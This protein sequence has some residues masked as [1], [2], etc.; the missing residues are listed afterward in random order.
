M[1]D[2]E[3]TLERIS[4]MMWPDAGI[5]RYTR[6]P[7]DQCEAAAL[8]V[9]NKLRSQNIDYEVR[10]LLAWESAEASGPEENHFVVIAK[11]QGH[12]IVI[13]MTVGQFFGTHR[14][15]YIIQNEKTWEAEFL[16]LESNQ[17]KLFKFKDFANMQL[18]SG[19]FWPPDLRF[20]HPEL[21][22]L[23]EAPSW[24]RDYFN[25]PRWG[26][27][28]L[29]YLDATRQPP[30][31]G[32]SAYTPEQRVAAEK[33]LGRLYAK[34]VAPFKEI[35]NKI[36]EGSLAPVTTL[37]T[38]DQL[39]NEAGAPAGT[40]Y[41]EI[42]D[43]LHLFHTQASTLNLAQKHAWLSDLAQL[44]D[45]YVDKHKFS[46]NGRR[47]KLRDFAR[48]VRAYA[49]SLRLRQGALNLQ[50]AVGRGQ[51][52]APSMV[53]LRRALQ[54]GVTD[55]EMGFDRQFLIQLTG[56]DA[57][58]SAAHNL[59]S[60]HPNK[61]EWY[62]CSQGA[63]NV[64]L[65]ASFGQFPP[66]GGGRYKFVLIGHGSQGAGGAQIG[67]LN[68]L[69]LPGI[70]NNAIANY[71]EGIV[72]QEGGSIDFRL[73]SLHV[74]LL[75]CELVE[76]FQAPEHTLP[77][78]LWERLVSHS[79]A[80]LSLLTRNQI[81]VTA[82]EYPVRVTDA[83]KKE[84]L[85]REWGW[86]GKEEARVKNVLYKVEI[87]NDPAT[88]RMMRKPIDWEGLNLLQQDLN[89]SPCSPTGLLE[90]GRLVEG[91]MHAT[92][93]EPATKSAL[94]GLHQTLGDEVRA[95]FIADVAP[96]AAQ[97]NMTAEQ[98]VVNIR[99]MA[100]GEQWA[101]VAHVLKQANELDGGD[102]SVTLKTRV[103][104]SGDTEVMFIRR[105]AS[106]STVPV[107]WVRT[108]AEQLTTLTSFKTELARLTV[109]VTKGL[110][111]SHAAN[112]VSVR[113]DVAEEDI[114]HTLNAAFMLQTLLD[115]GSNSNHYAELST[116]VKIEVFAGLSQFAFQSTVDG[117]RLIRFINQ[118]L[119][120]DVRVLAVASNGLLSRL[121]P[122]ANFVFNA[123]FIG[124]TIA[125]L[126]Q[127]TDPVVAEA[128]KVKLGLA[129]VYSG[130]D[131]TA[132]AAGLAGAGVVSGVLAAVATPLAGLA[133][134]IPLLVQ[135]YAALRAGFDHVS[136][137]F[138]W[139]MEGV[140]QPGLHERDSVWRAHPSAVIQSINFENG[141]LQ[142]GNV[143]VNA[144]G[145]GSGHTVTGGWDHF[146]ARPNPD[147]S[148]FLDVCSGLG[149]QDKLLSFDASRTQTVLLPGRANRKILF[150]YQQLTGRRTA[151][152]PALRRLRQHYG[153]Q[154]IWGMY[155]FP[156]DW[157]IY[158]ATEEL[159]VTEIA[160]TLNAANR[161]LVMPAVLSDDER[162]RLR[163]R[164]QGGGGQY[165]VV[166][167]AVSASI[168]IVASGAV[169]EQWLFDIDYVVMRH[170]IHDGQ[171]VLGDLK[172]DVF[173]DLAIQRHQFS[174]GGQSVS[175]PEGQAPQ[176]VTLSHTIASGITLL[177]SVDLV[178]QTRSVSVLLESAWSEQSKE[179]VRSFFSTGDA[180][181]LL[182]VEGRL[183][184]VIQ[185]QQAG[186]IDVRTGGILF[187]QVLQAT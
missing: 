51:W 7:V 152:A 183:D 2:F 122:G 12:R 15:A 84:V 96:G 158:R 30:S 98:A 118:A 138:D 72:F 182:N 162:N 25:Y 38:R 181:S 85:T 10:L 14:N 67:G 134:G 75:G 56:D 185:R 49:V 6:N 179:Q 35:E 8:A 135:N 136:E 125:E 52:R 159:D 163:Y 105:T 169:A 32:V 65:V 119:N 149:L 88:G 109:D 173:R 176:R 93:L 78:R 187:E 42:L 73:T 143:R 157:G 21:T 39:R 127:T 146:F 41:S 27:V 117:V 165:A 142:Y 111:W 66:N 91:T 174:I 20:T 43:S 46:L 26:E 126:H 86:I 150:D 64:N 68:E 164:L 120:A 58:F 137:Y 71:I 59:F 186:V 170:S 57:S 184:F 133:V 79:D 87:Q 83:G 99:S 171:I 172:L 123:I 77:G 114:P 107:R 160:V 108:N 110:E 166:L 29:D 131:V 168:V 101:S 31:R 92:D 5:I 129:I 175:F 161:T 140:A 62:Q 74:D 54:A 151:P 60:K 104:A 132:L 106:N 113:A 45:E 22:V 40:S 53:E 167:P 128:V 147:H 24:S 18:A 116:A 76:S 81:T 70:I 63:N 17:G 80:C 11:D 124:A 37:W 139:L 178:Q 177:L 4:S 145:G 94:V 1:E 102:W 23:G 28:K 48:H 155:A 3:T 50:S 33:S 13:D 130:I 89:N 95:Q 61:T 154:F 144:T 180:N 97:R 156:T 148:C 100:L 90:A 36:L 16:A 47:S 19:W 141:T 55:A 69:T 153:S 44:A 34:E 112:E 9:S 103:A 82:R 115:L 121:A